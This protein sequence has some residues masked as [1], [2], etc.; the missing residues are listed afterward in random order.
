MYKSRHMN[1]NVGG[2]ML[3]G[4]VNVQLVSSKILC[5]VNLFGAKKYIV[6]K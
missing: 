3:C 5:G 4:I 1:V 2:V 6:D